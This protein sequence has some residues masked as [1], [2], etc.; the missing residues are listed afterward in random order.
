MSSAS[1]HESTTIAENVLSK[2]GFL[3]FGWPQWITVNLRNWT[4]FLPAQQSIFHNRFVSLFVDCSTWCVENEMSSSVY[5]REI[6]V[7]FYISTFELNTISEVH[8]VISDMMHYYTWWL[9][10]AWTGQWSLQHDSTHRRTFQEV[11]YCLT[12][13][14]LVSV[15]MVS[16]TVLCTAKLTYHLADA[17]LR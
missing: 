4:I 17:M 13:K 11:T 3:T 15:H 1:S 2:N 8:P 7:C 9:K 10:K 16:L 5:T 14:Q 6:N 12:R